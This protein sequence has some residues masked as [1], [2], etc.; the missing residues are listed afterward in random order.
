M[1]VCLALAALTLA[2]AVQAQ[3]ADGAGF[4]AVLG[5]ASPERL[6]FRDASDPFLTVGYRLSSRADVQLGARFGTDDL[7][8]GQGTRGL[9]DPRATPQPGDVFQTDRR[10]RTV[11]VAGAV[12]TRVPAGRAEVRSRLSVGYDVLDRT[13]ETL[14]YPAAFERE[15]FDSGAVEAEVARGRATFAHAGAS[16]VVAVPL[17]GESG[18][19]APGVGL[20]VASSRRLAGTLSAP[21]SAA[22]AFVSLPT[23]VDVK[24]ARVTLD[25]TMGMGRS[26]DG[27]TPNE[28]RWSPH[29]E[30]GLRVDL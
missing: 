15:S 26:L 1:R 4:Y 2:A 24:G 22:M 16:A 14:R 19:V 8:V 18:R 23:T 9:Y 17:R 10:E 13:V 28:T 6:L 30:A 25:A 12:G 3:P 5:S 11:A 20:A 7:T 29:V 21:R 27:G